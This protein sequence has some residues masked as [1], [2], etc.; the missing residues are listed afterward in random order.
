MLQA[1]SRNTDEP[2]SRVEC[3]QLAASL[4]QVSCRSHGTDPT[5]NVQCCQAEPNQLNLLPR[6]GP[7]YFRAL[8]LHH[9]V[10]QLDNN[11]SYS[12]PKNDILPYQE[13]RCLF[14]LSLQPMLLGCMFAVMAVDFCD[15]VF[16][17]LH[18]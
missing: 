18:T 13:V 7:S 1:L 6:V 16:M 4:A 15:T 5:G 2:I 17:T 3:F 8:P 14:L 11:N 9:L 12:D 10:L